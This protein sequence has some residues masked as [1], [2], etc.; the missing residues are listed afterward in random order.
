MFSVFVNDEVT[1]SVRYKK[2][3]RLQRLFH[4]RYRRP[5][6]SGQWKKRKIPNPNTVPRTELM[7][8][9]QLPTRKLMV[10]TCFS[11][12]GLLV[13]LFVSDDADHFVPV[14]HFGL[15]AD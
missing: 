6:F 13:D 5:P 12:L 11:L 15:T 4:C 1:N 9:K 10:I 3:S 2:K 14:E 8:L 7:I